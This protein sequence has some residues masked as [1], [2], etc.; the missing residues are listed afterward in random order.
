M[1]LLHSVHSLPATG[2]NPMRDMALTDPAGVR[3]GAVNYLNSKP[4]IEGLTAELATVAPQAELFLDYPSRLADDLSRGHL[5]VALIPSVECL[6]DPGYE[7]VTDACVAAHGPVLSVKLYSRVPVEDIGSLALDEGSRTSAT[8]AR[9]LLSERFG[10]RPELDLLP[11][12]RSIAT[13]NADAVLLIGD[14]AMHPV[15]ADFVET[16]DLG[17]VW[18]DW[19]GLPFVFALW[20]TRRGTPLGRVEE[21]LTTARDRGLTRLSEIGAREAGALGIAPSTAVNYLTR[22]LHFRL[23][24]SERQGLAL[25]RRLSIA[26]GLIAGEIEMAFRDCGIPG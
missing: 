14:R 8:L 26:Q 21:A 6:R 19:T 18:S 16:W 24:P 3:I 5:D 10:V 22:N 2:R 11:L 7:I 1:S 25:F 4:L 20:A 23:G 13:S 17:E 15:E 9:L 12:G